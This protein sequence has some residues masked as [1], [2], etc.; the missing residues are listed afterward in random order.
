M[1]F[2]TLGRS[3]ARKRARTLVNAATVS[4]ASVVDAGGRVAAV[5]EVTSE[6][7]LQATAAARIKTECEKRPVPWI[8]VNHSSM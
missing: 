4:S 3:S 7:C 2:E 5:S 1:T 8:F 6:V